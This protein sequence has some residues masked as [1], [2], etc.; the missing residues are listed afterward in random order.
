MGGWGPQAG[1]WDHFACSWGQVG[2]A[3][4]GGEAWWAREAPLLAACRQRQQTSQWWPGSWPS[5][6]GRGWATARVRARA[7][8]CQAR[9]ARLGLPG[10]GCHGT[11][12][13]LPTEVGGPRGGGHGDRPLGA[14]QSLAPPSQHWNL[15]DDKKPGCRDVSAQRSRPQARAASGV[16]NLAAQAGWE[17]SSGGSGSGLGLRLL[18][19]LWGGR[20]RGLHAVLQGQGPGSGLQAAQGPVLHGL[21]LHGAPQFLGWRQGLVDAP[22]EV[23]QPHQQGR[24]EVGDKEHQEVHEVDEKVAMGTRNW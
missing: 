9:G 15:D 1:F 2:S 13:G 20:P 21:L 5:I 7:E 11:S 22:S 24:E 16:R 8:G 3:S 19:L 6:P 17:S 12:Q 4:Q 23:L 10:S 18:A 14:R